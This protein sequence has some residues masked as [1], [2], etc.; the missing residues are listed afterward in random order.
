MFEEMT[1]E[2]ILAPR[3]RFGFLV[4]LGIQYRMMRKDIE[5]F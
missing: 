3:S 4:A 1:C 2:N 5:T